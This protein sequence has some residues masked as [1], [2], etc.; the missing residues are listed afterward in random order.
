MSVDFGQFQTGMPLGTQYSSDEAYRIAMGENRPISELNLSP[1]GPVVDNQPDSTA[2]TEPTF[3]PT[4]QMTA[5]ETA[6]LAQSQK[7]ETARQQ[8]AIATM[9]ALLTSYNMSSLFNRVKSYIQDGYEADAIM[10]LIRTTPEYKERF[11]AM[12]SLAKKGRAISEASYIDYEKAAAGLERRYG[13]PNG[14]LMGNVTKLLENEVSTDELNTRVTLAAGASIQ[15]PNEVR[16]AL[17]NYY[18]IDQGGLTAYFLD[19]SIATPLLEKQYAS[20][21]IGAEAIRQNVGIDVGIAENLQGLGV[22]SQQAREGFGAIAGAKSLTSG[23]GDIVTQQQQIGAVLGGNSEDQKAL[24]RAIGGRLG[25]FQGGGEFLQTQQ[26]A[27][28]LGSAA[29]R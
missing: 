18:N 12:E 6:L 9:E 14:M 24:E 17:R 28:G 23:Y 22:T 8:N 16:E 2:S 25:R 27:A 13:L 15:A 7:A 26:G 19:P 5:Y 3:D 20:A 4:K 21:Q 11:P 10:A 1:R 29:T